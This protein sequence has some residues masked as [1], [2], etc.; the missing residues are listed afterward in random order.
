MPEFNVIKCRHCGANNRIPEK[1]TTLPAKCGRCGKLLPADAAPPAILT[2]RCGKCHVKNRV[3]ETKLHSGA[4]CGRCGEALETKDVRSG[5][6][7]MV[8]DGNFDR[9]VLAS[10]LPV[11]LY[12]WS[13]QCSVC[14]STGPMVDQLAM[15]TKGKIRVGKLNTLTN[16]VL[17]H[18][19][20][21]LA[22][23]S[24]FIFDGGQLKRHLPGAVPKHDLMLEMA[25]YL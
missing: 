7:V 4:K 17:S 16:P 10:P 23:P 5:R 13:P 15:E 24:F 20:N 3:P 14:G 8:S 12:G 25:K 22:V 6:P 21:I 18:K 1:K 11:L 2:L 19:F 9:T